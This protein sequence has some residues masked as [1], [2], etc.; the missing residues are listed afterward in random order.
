[1]RKVLFVIPHFYA[2]GSGFYGSTGRDATTR[3]IA[4]GK[5]IEGLHQSIGSRQAFLLWLQGYVAGQGNGKVIR[6]NETIASE[7]DIVLC[8]SGQS[9]LIPSIPVHSSLF[10]H[11]ET[12]A[13]PM[14][15]GFACHQ[16]LRE[17]LGKYDWYC[18]LED[19]LFIADPL[20][21]NKLE[22]FIFEHGE[23]TTLS[24]H[25]YE[26]SLS[27]P[28]HKLY[29]DG[30]VRP[31]FT[32]AWQD[33]SDRRNLESSALG[34][35]LRFERWPNPHSGCFFLNAS[36]MEK[37]ASQPYFGDCDAGFAGPLESAASLGIMKT[38]RQYKPSPE[39]AAFFELEH[40]HPRYLGEQL[41]FS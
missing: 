19:D 41:K 40:L 13:E 5:V 24:P 10:R 28:A 39:N 2:P 37:W 36:Q 25:R 1:M 22:W 7:L 8:T 30:S 21:F 23:E 32:A 33:I 34:M 29:I 27:Q 16:V 11:Q 26:R 3:G 6:A 15:L 20:L 35:T 9:H 12:G 17:H 18:F 4:L 14:Q 38:F 31:D